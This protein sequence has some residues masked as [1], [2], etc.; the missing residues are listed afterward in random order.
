MTMYQLMDE[1]YLGMPDEH[2]AFFRAQVD[3]IKQL[4]EENDRKLAE[5][6]KKHQ[7]ENAVKNEM[8]DILSA[9]E[10]KVDTLVSAGMIEEAD[11]VLKEIQ[12][13][14]PAL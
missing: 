13:Y 2:Y 1:I 12:K 8:R 9:L 5:E 10:K 4:I 14:T 7:A 3:A 11:M 6:Q